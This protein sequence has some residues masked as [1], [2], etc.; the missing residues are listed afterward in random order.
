MAEAALELVAP[1][2]GLDVVMH[3][4]PVRGMGED[5]N[6]LAPTAPLLVATGIEEK[7]VE[8]GIPALGITED[9]QVAPRPKQRFLHGILGRCLVSEDSGRE[10]EEPV[11]R[12]CRE[13]LERRVVASLRPLHKLARHTLPRSRR[14]RPLRRPASMAISFDTIST[15]M[16]HK[17]AESINPVPSRRCSNGRRWQTGRA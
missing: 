12:R 16:T 10:R 9:A 4:R 8:P 15:C 7:S 11:D 3:A 17:S 1:R 2:E 14:P 5:R 6:G 13:L